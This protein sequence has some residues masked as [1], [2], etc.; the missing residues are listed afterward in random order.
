M[1]IGKNGYVAQ[2]IG[3][4]EKDGSWSP[5]VIHAKWIFP[6]AEK[7]PNKCLNVPNLNP[8]SN[9][10]LTLTRIIRNLRHPT[11][12]TRILGYAFL[13]LVNVVTE[14]SSF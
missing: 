5:K 8:N 14:Q 3:S 2:D 12:H 7:G 1:S 4:G 9:P 10:A 11:A 6:V 13:V